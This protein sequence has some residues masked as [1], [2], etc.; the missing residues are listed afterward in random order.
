[1]ALRADSVLTARV[2]SGDEDRARVRR[3][4]QNLLQADEAGASAGASAGA[5]ARRDMG[6]EEGGEP[7]AITPPALPLP[8]QMTRLS[9]MQK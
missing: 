2:S 1:M 3:W 8:G 7:S 5:E 6:A 9:L 4:T